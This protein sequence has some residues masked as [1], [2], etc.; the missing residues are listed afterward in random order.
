MKCPDATGE[1]LGLTL[2]LAWFGSVELGFCTVAPTTAISSWLG[3][4]L[5]L[6]CFANAQI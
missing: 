3:L 4:A 1:R 2:G 6:S 5:G